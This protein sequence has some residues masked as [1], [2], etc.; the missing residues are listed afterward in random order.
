[1]IHA[2]GGSAPVGFSAELSG[3]GSAGRGCI[4]ACS[5]IAG[6][7]TEKGLPAAWAAEI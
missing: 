3:W 1:V 5:T 6:S 4:G 2:R 7:Y